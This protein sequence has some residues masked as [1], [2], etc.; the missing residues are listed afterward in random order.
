[1]AEK[2]RLGGHPKWKKKKKVANNKFGLVVVIHTFGRDGTFNPHFH[3]LMTKGFFDEEH[4]FFPINYINFKFLRI[5]WQN[6]VLKLLKELFP[7]DQ[8]IKNLINLN[9]SNKNG[10][11]VNAEIDIFQ[12]KG[13]AKYIG[14][15]LARPAIAEYRILDFSDGK[16][17]YWYEDT[18]SK[19]KLTTSIS[20]EQFI[21]RVFSH[22]PHK[23]FKLVHRFGLY[24]RRILQKNK[25]IFEKFKTMLFKIPALS[26]IDRILAYTG[27]HPFQCEKCSFFMKIIRLYHYKYGEIRYP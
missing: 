1:M 13:I 11:Y 20:V 22:V 5:A 21:F 27:K 14:R 25:D 18:R 7:S 8:Y 12:P 2:R 10:F 19:S 9:Y 24:S 3:C 6:A 23:H 4:N 15:Y 26:W 16:V 17:T